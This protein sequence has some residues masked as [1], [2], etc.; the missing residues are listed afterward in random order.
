[1]NFVGACLLSFLAAGT[2]QTV[3]GPG[4]STPSNE[5]IVFTVPSLP[6][7]RSFQRVV[8]ASAEEARRLGLSPKDLMLVKLRGVTQ[9]R[10]MQWDE[11][12]KEPYF[13]LPTQ[14]AGESTEAVLIKAE[15]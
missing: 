8:L 5:G 4:A 12:T 6:A 10:P 3:G 2:E 14:A 15:S 1:M 13:L 11:R 9:P 7:K